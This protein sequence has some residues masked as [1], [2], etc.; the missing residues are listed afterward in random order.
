MV[1]KIGKRFKGYPETKKQIRQTSWGKN[2][3]KSGMKSLKRLGKLGNE[4]RYP[5]K[6]R[7]QKVIYKNCRDPTRRKK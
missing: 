4:L 6:S 2:V 5:K 7:S 3:S 1:I